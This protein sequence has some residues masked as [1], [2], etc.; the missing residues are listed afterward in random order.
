MSTTVSYTGR[1]NE[2]T[3]GRYTATIVDGDGNAITLAVLTTLTLTL[4]DENSKVII[5][6]RD[7]QNILNANNVTVSA[8][9][10]LVWTIQALD[11]PILDD[12]LDTELHI[13]LFQ[14]T[15]NGGADSGKHSVGLRVLNF[16]KVS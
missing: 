2:K 11:N 1:Q 15:Y 3:T 16:E 6:S 5:N 13:A 10:V 7:G 14:W 8:G 4:F 9:C 12:S